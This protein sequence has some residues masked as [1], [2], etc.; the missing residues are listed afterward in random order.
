MEDELT[1][2]KVLSMV[3]VGFARSELAESEGKLA[4]ARSAGWSV[5][6]WGGVILL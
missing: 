5:A 4:S 1:L 6:G 3:E 2:T